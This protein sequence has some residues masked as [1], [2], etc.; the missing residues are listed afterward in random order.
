MANVEYR[1]LLLKI[2][3]TIK[4]ILM[5]MVRKGIKFTSY[6]FTAAIAL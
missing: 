4:F 3:S 6:K 1:V 5:L 2:S